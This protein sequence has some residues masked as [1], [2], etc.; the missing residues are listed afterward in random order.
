MTSVRGLNIQVM[1][2]LC[3]NEKV[4]DNP[5]FY[6]KEYVPQRYGPTIT[7]EKKHKATDSPKNF[8]TSTCGEGEWEGELVIYP[9]HH[10]L[11]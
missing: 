3:G 6:K 10:L 9:T 11:F 1:A 8:K 4:T 2:N 7:R 5:I